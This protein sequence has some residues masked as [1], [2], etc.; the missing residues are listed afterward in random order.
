MRPSHGAL[1][2]TPAG[3]SPP[4]VPE[5]PTLVLPPE[6][7]APPD[8][9]LP[10][11]PP[12]PHEKSP[13]PAP[14]L[15]SEHVSC[16]RRPLLQGSQHCSMR[17]SQ[18]SPAVASEGQSPPLDGWAA[19]TE[20]CPASC[21]DRKH[22]VALELHP[23]T[24][25]HDALADSPLH[26]LAAAH[27]FVQT[28]H[29]HFRLPHCASEEQS[30]IQCVLLSVPASE[31]L[32]AQAI[33]MALPRVSI[34]ARRRGVVFFMGILISSFAFNVVVGSLD[35]LPHV[36]GHARALLGIRRMLFVVR[37]D[38]LPQRLRRQPGAA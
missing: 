38:L 7:L 36:E 23:G 22:T 13:L 28:P 6:P 10:P 29:S 31:E 21:A 16:P 8:P 37:R 19:S 25:A 1:P 20:G 2:C 9:V 14:H 3:Q 27:G 26:S 5:P 4:V 35:R 12:V 11:V 30:F 32:S 15:L 18:W 33:A 17:P 24:A 34:S